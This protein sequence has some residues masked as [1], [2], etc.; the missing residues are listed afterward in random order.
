M[1][2]ILEVVLQEI[3]RVTGMQDV[4]PADR[5]YWDL[6][7]FTAQSLARDYGFEHI[8]IPVIEYTDLFVRGA[9]TASDFFV[10]KEMYTIEEEDGTSIT[11]RPEFTAGMVRAYI[12]NGMQNWPQPVK[13]YAIGPCFRRERPQAGRYRQHSQFNCEILGETDPAADVEVM[14]LCMNLYRQLGYKGLTFQVNSTG[15]PACKPVYVEAL[16]AYL[17]DHMDKLAPVDLERLRRNPLRV[18]DSKE[19]GMDTLLAQAPHIVDY[20]CDDCASHFAELRGLLDALGQEYKVNFRLVRGIDYYV[21]T[22]FEVWAEGIGAQAAVVGGGR[23]DGLAEAIGGPSTPGVGFGSGIE[24]VILGM[25]EYGIEL[26]P[27]PSVPVMVAHFGGETKIAANQL[28]YALRDAGIGAR[29]AFAREK[30]S[31]KSQMREANKHNARFVIILGE[32]EVA[33]QAVAVKSMADD[34]EQ[35]RIPQAE[36]LAYLSARL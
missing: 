26:P 11:L 35:V 5:R 31:L 22:V 32:S 24:R 36:L 17:A 12:N 8:D 14:M 29:V 23:Y 21:K 18:L 7:L 27:A 4:L 3:Q 34:G 19:P 1:A 16:K 28:V 9:G 15:C 13:L 2:S 6:V 10:Q 30:R 25:K 20:L 33:D